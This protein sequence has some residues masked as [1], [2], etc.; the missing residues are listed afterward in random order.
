MVLIQQPPP[1]AVVTE[2]K[3]LLLPCSA[4]C[5]GEVAIYL[6]IYMCRVR[7]NAYSFMFFAGLDGDLDE[8]S[9]FADNSD[10]ESSS[11]TDFNDNISSDMD[12]SADDTESTVKRHKRVSTEHVHQNNF[13]NF[14]VSFFFF[15]F[16][17]SFQQYYT[18]GTETS[19]LFQ[20]IQMNLK[21]L[22]TARLRLFFQRWLLLCT[23][24]LSMV[25][26]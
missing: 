13:T 17:R 8:N 23:I 7:L 16:Y 22:K 6:Y 10:Y 15:V 25:C 5:T 24:A 9:S 14:G 4:K 3:P 20:R 19:N 18:S 12:H 11:K 21:N 26:I 1:S 2:L